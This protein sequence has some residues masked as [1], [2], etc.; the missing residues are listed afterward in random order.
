MVP[1]AIVVPHSKSE[2]QDEDA[3]APPMTKGKYVPG[4]YIVEISDG[5]STDEFIS[6]LGAQ[7]GVASIEERI[8][9]DSTVFKGTSFNLGTVQ[10]QDEEEVVRQVE[11]SPEVKNIWPVE[12]I[13][14]PQLNLSWTAQ[15][16]P[17]V[18]VQRR[19]VGKDGYSPHIMTQVDRLHAEGI[20]GK[21]LRIGIV[22]TGI[23]YTHPALGGCFG[24]GC[25]VEFGAD[26]VGDSYDGSQPPNP[27][28]DPFENCNGHGT[29]VAG[30]IAA[31]D[32][33]LGFKGAAPGVKIGMFR[34]FSCSDTTT[35][36][37]LMAATSKA[38]E[39]GSDIITGS[40]GMASG[41]SQNPFA[42]LVSRIVEAGVPC[43][44]SAG[45]EVGGTEGLFSVSAPSTGDGVISVSSFQNTHDPSYNATSGQ[46]SEILNTDTGGAVSTF[47]SWG[48]TFDLKNKPDVGAPGGNILSTL[49][50]AQGGYGVAS[51][52]SMSCPL[53]AA[54]VAL[55]VESRNTSDPR[56][57]QGIL[58][59]SA[60][61]S[62]SY[63]MSTGWPVLSPGL[64]P[65]PQ[66]GAGLVQ[67]YDA[68]HSTV[69][70]SATQ[71][72]FNDTENF[73]SEQ[74][75]TIRNEGNLSVTYAIGHRPALTAD[76]L[77]S[78]TVYKHSSPPLTSAYAELS[79][80]PSRITVQPGKEV[81]VLVSAIPP[82]DVDIS[83]L[84][85]YS[86]WIT[87]NDNS[88]ETS[89]SQL[90]LP[91]IG[92]AGAMRNTTVMASSRMWT[93]RSDDWRSSPLPAGATAQLSAPPNHKNWTRKPLEVSD[94][95]LPPGALPS[96]FIWL[97]MGSAEVRLEL[98]LLA[99]SCLTAAPQQEQ[100]GLGDL[101]VGN[102]EGYPRTYH[103]NLGWAS[104]WNGRMADGS[105]APP[106]RY[107][108]IVSALRT[109]GN[110]SDVK[111]WDRFIS[112]DFRVRYV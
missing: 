79:F 30:I 23:D 110:R 56:E 85:I 16:K 112:T 108:F 17:L 39:D 109:F 83:A 32:N 11:A 59:M 48:P 46:A 90:V 43:T 69:F 5:Q 44:F 95:I 63:D 77:W 4:A 68:I 10:K 62:R 78:G 27:D 82:K 28:G 42:L 1:D 91:Y 22:D 2:S 86:G 71:L 80:S 52:T 111:D 81:Q 20:T 64:G 26:V 100:N 12:V 103:R 37:A 6:R 40:I 76:T 101:T 13:S 105:W 14:S 7:E 34:A 24:P 53:L 70:L 51:G 75:F 57:I 31:L 97:V 54:I 47:T 15:G 66:Q 58:S 106:G 41:W 87:L 94:L 8:R 89:S 35:M 98:Q 93:T 25:L 92:A 96:Q 67:A 19:Q 3:I 73:L 38:Y 45:N 102:I 18:E 60:K 107:R 36:D 99:P 55:V 49:P 29:H 74:T 84:P 33:P 88:S 21:G 72:S 65:V 9:F 50:L 61:P 104:S